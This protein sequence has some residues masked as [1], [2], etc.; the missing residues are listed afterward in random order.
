M[1]RIARPMV[2]FSLIVACT[3]CVLLGADP[4]EF[5]ARVHQAVE[6]S[7]PLL[8]IASAETA[9]RRTCF[10]CHGQA[11]PAVVLK[12]AKE[13]GFHI[14]ENNLQRQVLYDEEDVAAGIP[15]AIAAEQRL[16]KINSQV[17]IEALVAERPYYAMAT[18][19][20]GLYN[21]NDEDVTTFGVRATFVTS[22]DVEEDTV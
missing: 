4:T 12:E 11:M 9:E 6:R 18:I 8:E 17:E 13:H 20:G 5:T 19:P 2:A 15:K 14:D 3:H 16:R 1:L 7:L 22:A 21:G 10:T